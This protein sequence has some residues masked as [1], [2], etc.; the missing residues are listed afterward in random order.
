MKKIIFTLVLF[1]T[2]ISSL[3]AVE[4]DYELASE[5]NTVSG[6]QIVVP[7]DITWTQRFILTELKELRI[8]LES[9]KRELNEELNK[10]ELETV[11][12]ALSYSGNTVNF[13]WLIMTMAVTGFWLVGW[14]TMKDVRENLTNN[15]ETQIQK[16]VGTQQKRLEQFMQKFEQEQLAQSKE[17]LENQE[18]IQKKQEGA[19]YWS[20]FNREEDWVVRLELLEKIA[21]LVVEEDELLILVERALIYVTLGLW[22]KA[23]E[24]ADKGLEIASE[25]TTLLYSKAEALVMLEDSDEA[26]KVINNILVVKPVM[27]EEIMEDSTFENLHSDIEAIVEDNGNITQN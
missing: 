20:Q 12:R 19:Y 16:N 8:Q 15:F 11:D 6:S 10:R 24:V 4:L 17:I 2:N 27:K 14:R 13:L 3:W 7:E 26:L 21:W 18:M 23:L 25:N 5:V 9:T 22:D 1:F